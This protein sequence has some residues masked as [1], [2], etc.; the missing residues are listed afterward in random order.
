LKSSAARGGSRRRQSTYTASKT[1]GVAGGVTG[2]KWRCD[3][4]VNTAIVMAGFNQMN[5][6]DSSAILDPVVWDRGDYTKGNR[7]SAGNAWNQSLSRPITGKR[8]PTATKV[9]SN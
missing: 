7:L 4:K 5:P 8:R 3:N 9:T 1:R 2:H 6:A